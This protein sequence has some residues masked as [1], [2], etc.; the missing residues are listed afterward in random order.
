MT[1]SWLHSSLLSPRTLCRDDGS[2]WSQENFPWGIAPCLDLAPNVTH[3][4]REHQLP[5]SG[6]AAVLKHPWTD[7]LSPWRSR[8]KHNPKV[9]VPS[10]GM[11]PP[12]CSQ[13]PGRSNIPVSHAWIHACDPSWTHACGPSHGMA[14]EEAARVSRQCWL[15]PKVLFAASVPAS[16]DRTFIF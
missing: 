16:S 7:S 11:Q 13:P 14:P 6:K 10:L 4:P 2:V 5:N 8:D 15:W 12:S 3:F 1:F 9:M